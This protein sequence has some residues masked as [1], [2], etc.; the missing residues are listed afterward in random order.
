MSV[1]GWSVGE[2]PSESRHENLSFTVTFTRERFLEV[3]DGH[4]W[5]ECTTND[6]LSHCSRPS[7]RIALVPDVDS[8]GFSS[9][10]KAYRIPL[11]NKRSEG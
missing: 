3:W 9:P 2:C 4:H 8:N 1:H 10:P 11:H 6:K 7:S 5:K